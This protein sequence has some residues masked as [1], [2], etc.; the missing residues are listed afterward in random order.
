M[1]CLNNGIVDN[2][3][4]KI[5]SENIN[6]IF[7]A[8]YAEKVDIQNVP[9]KRNL[10]IFRQILRWLVQNLIGKKSTRDCKYTFR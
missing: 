4:K 8:N 3:I 7:G 1:K 2:K 5:V 6:N 10:G 9:R